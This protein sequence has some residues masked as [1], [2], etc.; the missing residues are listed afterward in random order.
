M[1]AL[2]AG[3]GSY[4]VRLSVHDLHGPTQGKGYR[5]NKTG[6]DNCVECLQMCNSAAE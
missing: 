3:S 1:N 5:D 2:V 4:I 6:R